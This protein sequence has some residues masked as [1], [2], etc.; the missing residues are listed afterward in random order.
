M[1]F[2]DQPARHLLVRWIWAETSINRAQA[3]ILGS[4][5][6][7][8][9]WAMTFT[10]YEAVYTRGVWGTDFH[11]DPQCRL[12]ATLI[13]V[14][15]AGGTLSVSLLLL[16]FSIKVIRGDEEEGE[17]PLQASVTLASMVIGWI[18]FPY[19]VNGVFQ[20]FAGNR[21]VAA[22]M[23]VLDFDPKALMPTSWLGGYWWGAAVLLFYV[24]SLGIPAL[25]LVDIAYA[26]WTKHWRQAGFI[27]CCLVVVAA[28]LYLS[29]NLGG[30]L[31]D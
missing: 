4:L 30:W 21:E 11:L 20:A 9:I 27:A 26:L 24:L 17:L 2:S 12:R 15:L 25:V 14:G 1:R 10:P 13:G 23:Q 6:A 3:V 5:V 19:W 18:A 22:R 16:A 8:G 28:I 29:P 31:F 7:L